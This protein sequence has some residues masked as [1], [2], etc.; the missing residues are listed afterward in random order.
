M[1][2]Y[3]NEEREKALHFDGRTLAAMANA[4]ATVAIAQMMVNESNTGERITED[5]NTMR[6]TA[7][8]RPVYYSP[9]DGKYLHVD[10]GFYDDHIARP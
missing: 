7:C 9:A 4:H 3:L 2:N 10:G 8:S 6:C 5:S 1:L